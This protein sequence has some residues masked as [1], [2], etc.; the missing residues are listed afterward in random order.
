MLPVEPTAQALPA[1]VAATPR[2]AP[3]M[4]KKAA[5]SRDLVPATA[6]AGATSA[7]TPASNSGTAT[8]L[9]E[10]MM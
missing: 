1:D 10:R 7:P 4:A 3:L 2:R 5:R 8:S 6:A 9:T